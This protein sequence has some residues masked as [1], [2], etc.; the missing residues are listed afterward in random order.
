M[1]NSGEIN[2]CECIMQNIVQSGD[3]SLYFKKYFIAYC[4]EKLC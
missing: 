2:E 4:I 1:H 3:V